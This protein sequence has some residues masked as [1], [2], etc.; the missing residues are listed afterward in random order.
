MS[1]LDGVLQ[2]AL[3]YRVTWMDDGH[4]VREAQLSLE[5]VLDAVRGYS[6]DYLS[7]Q[8]ANW[9]RGLHLIRVEYDSQEAHRTLYRALTLLRVQGFPRSRA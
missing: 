6:L 9:S 3:P 1:L 2:G 5:A 8:E 7:S 4:P